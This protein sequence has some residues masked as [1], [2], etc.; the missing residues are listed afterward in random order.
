MNIDYKSYFILF[1]I[2]TFYRIPDV[3][4]IF[5]LNDKN[6]ENFVYKQLFINDSL[7]IIFISLTTYFLLKY[8]YY[9]HHII[10]V[11]IFII[12]SV[13]ND[14]LLDNYIN[15]NLYTILSSILYV[16]VNGIYY[17]YLKYMIEYKYLYFLDILFFAGVFNFITY[18]ISFILYIIV[19]IVN[20]KKTVY[21]ELF[22]FY[23][24]YGA[25]R[26]IL[27]FLFGIFV[28]G[29][30]IDSIEYAIINEITP[31][32]VII[33]IEISKIPSSI[34]GIEGNKK[35]FVLI[36]SIFQIFSTLFYL[37]IL[38]FNFCSLNK[39]TKKN[40]MK[41]E[42][43]SFFFPDSNSE[44]DIKGYDISDGFENQEKVKELETF[45]VGSL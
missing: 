36:V 27:P 44:I 28:S 14:L 42:T 9:I 16:V 2:L 29:F 34:M 21:F 35:W 38:E 13:I 25:W 6:E 45:N 43:N 37:E 12:L 1:L 33:G 17:S 26:I 7:E 41:R 24:E 4:E 32:Y 31:N 30:S 3:L 8:K 19:N 23:N 20:G 18:F 39:N 22:D 11:V 40:I 10:S 15:V 5:I